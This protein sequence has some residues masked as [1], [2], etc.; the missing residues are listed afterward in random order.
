MERPKPPSETDSV[1]SIRQSMIDRRNKLMKEW[2]EGIEDT[3]LFSHVI[4]W[5]YY[6][7]ELH[8]YVS[9]MEKPFCGI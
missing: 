7:K 9:E 1:E 6:C 4:A 2:P 5:L 8:E 3:V